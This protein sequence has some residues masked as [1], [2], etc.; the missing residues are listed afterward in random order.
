MA[1]GTGFLVIELLFV[2]A[3]MGGLAEF[4]VIASGGGGIEGGG[5]VSLVEAEKM[6]KISTPPRVWKESPRQGIM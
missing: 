3:D 2:V 5:R 6:L 4:V 1:D